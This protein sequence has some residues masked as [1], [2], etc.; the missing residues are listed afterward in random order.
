MPIKDNTRTSIGWF[1]SGFVGRPASGTAYVARQV[2]EKLL[3]SYS[4]EFEVVLFTKNAEETTAVQ[5]DKLLSY[6]TVVQLPNVK[7]QY[8]SGSRQ[9]Y[10]YCGLD[11]EMVDILHFS[12]ARVYPFFYKFPAKKFFCTFHAAGDVTVKADKF[13]LSKYIYNWITKL[14]WKHFDA[15]IAVSEFARNE[16]IENYGVA[17]AAI[18]IIPPGVDSF[19]AAKVQAVESI[20]TDSPIIAVM[21][22]W[23]TFKN[24]AFACQ[25]IREINNRTSEHN[26]LVV[27]GRSNVDGRKTVENEISQHPIQ[28]ISV[29]EY[30]EPGEL[31]WLYKKATLIIIPSLNEGFGMPSFEAYAGGARI[32]VHEGTPAATILKNQAGV[33]SCDLRNQ[34]VTQAIIKSILSNPKSINDTERVAMVKNRK[35]TWIDF[36]EKYAN[37]YREQSNY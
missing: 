12:V 19:L 28:E 5:N 21:G 6:A 3:S 14:Q 23:Q 35:L 18:R 36:G 9:F 17:K 13:V 30:L 22:R 10:K 4:S 26:H 31:V 8:L 11:K 25:A 27:V 32:L 37:L 15:I 20:I 2:V 29:L 1:A 7:F 16:I 34:K 24:V 33:Y